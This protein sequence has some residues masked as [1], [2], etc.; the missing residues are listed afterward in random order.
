MKRALL[1]IAVLLLAP[2]T[3]ACTGVTMGV[4][5]RG[6]YYRPGEPDPDLWVEGFGELRGLL[7]ARHVLGP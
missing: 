3:L 5:V 1:A 2:G 7:D 4:G 6:G